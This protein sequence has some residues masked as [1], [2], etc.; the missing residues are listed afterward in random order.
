MITNEE[1]NK[2]LQK[3]ND[4]GFKVL[5]S[6]GSLDNLLEEIDGDYFNEKVNE[7][8][9]D[10]NKQRIVIDVEEQGNKEDFISKVKHLLK[11]NCTCG[12]VNEEFCKF[13]W[14]IE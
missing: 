6:G 13:K 14:R 11:G 10:N 8:I 4:Y 9:I 2:I 7:A 5:C 3:L 12:E 1:T